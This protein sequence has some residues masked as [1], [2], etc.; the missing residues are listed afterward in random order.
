MDERKRGLPAFTALVAFEA[1]GRHLNFTRAAQ[2]LGISQAAVS[3]QI[4]RLEAEAGTALFRRL[5]RAVALTD[6]GAELHR[7]V[8]GGFDDIATAVTRIRRERRPVGVAANNAVAFYWLRPRITAFRHAHPDIELAV[9]ASDTDLP[10]DGEEVDLAVRYGSGHW[11]DTEAV[12]LFGETLFPVCSPDYL[13]DAP[14]LDTPR[15]LLGHALL[16][17]RPHG[18][19]WVTWTEWLAAQG[20]DAAERL[21]SGLT[22]DSYPVLLQAALDGH[23]VAIGTAHLLDPLLDSGALVRPLAGTYRTGRGYYLVQ[24]AGGPRNADTRRVAHWLRGT[25]TGAPDAG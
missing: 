15:D 17:M 19:D 16:Y 10:L 3:R 2:E 14:P 24:P 4:H 6:A 23:G 20:V 13:A 9:F 5:H 22:F 8:S 25:A 7:S 12:A 18:R 1:A 11:P 21:P